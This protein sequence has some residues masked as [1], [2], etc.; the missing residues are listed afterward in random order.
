MSMNFNDIILATGV[1]SEHPVV[2]RLTTD[3]GQ[4]FCT[5]AF[6]SKESALGEI[7][8]ILNSVTWIDVLNGYVRTSSVM[9]I[10]AFDTRS[11]L[12]MNEATKT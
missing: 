8:R 11:K 4:M 6:E 9:A 3:A 10:H 1:D 2:V 12:D 5:R 7:R